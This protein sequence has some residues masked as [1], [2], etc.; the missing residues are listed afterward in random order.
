M[1][2]THAKS[3]IPSTSVDH[4][5]PRVQALQELISNWTMEEFVGFVERI[6]AEV[7]KLNLRQGTEAWDRCEEVK[8]YILDFARMQFCEADNVLTPAD[9]QV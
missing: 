7:E 5:E 6:E 8:S 9:V 1:A 3:Q 4:D 2:W